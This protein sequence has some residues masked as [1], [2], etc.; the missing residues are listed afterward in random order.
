MELIRIPALSDNYIWLLCDE[1]KHCVIIDP[2]ES[3]PVIDI[4]A[5]NKIIPVAFARYVIGAQTAW[6]APEIAGN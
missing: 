3:L 2:A 4:L 5:A 6:F 1:D